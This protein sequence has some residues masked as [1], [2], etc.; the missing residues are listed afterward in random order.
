VCVAQMPIAA[1]EPGVERIWNTVN[2]KHVPQPRV[3]LQAFADN[4]SRG[5]FLTLLWQPQESQHTLCFV[6]ASGLPLWLSSF[7]STSR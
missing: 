4:P 7:P 1:A 2:Q 3:P 6:M 5:D